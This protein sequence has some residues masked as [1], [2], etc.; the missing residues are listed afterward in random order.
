MGARYEWFSDLDGART[1][2]SHIQN[3]LTFTPAVNLTESLLLRVEYRYDWSNQ[4]IF[5]TSDGLFSKG[6]TSKVSTEL[7]YK[8]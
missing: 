4:L 7:I 1:G 8:F 5:E 6:E 3:G 2:V